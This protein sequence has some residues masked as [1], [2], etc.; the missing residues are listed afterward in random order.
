MTS[1]KHYRLGCGESLQSNW[2]E[3]E[4]VAKARSAQRA[5]PKLQLLRKLKQGKQH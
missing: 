3:L 2:L 4:R 1:M 5:Q